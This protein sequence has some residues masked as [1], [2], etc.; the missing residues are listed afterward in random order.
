ML[1]DCA[2]LAAKYAQFFCM[3]AAVSCRAWRVL[4]L[5]TS[6]QPLWWSCSLLCRS[7]KMLHCAFLATHPTYRQLQGLTTAARDYTP[8]AGASC[9]S[10]LSDCSRQ[11]DQ[12]VWKVE[13]HMRACY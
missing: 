6:S 2:V 3:L 9:Q 8:A 13:Q 10:V 4:L 12:L 7:P 5:V 1:A 11:Y